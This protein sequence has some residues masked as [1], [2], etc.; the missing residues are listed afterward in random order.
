MCIYETQGPSMPVAHIR[1]G[2][3]RILETLGIARKLSYNQTRNLHRLPHRLHSLAT[4]STNIR[5]LRRF[6]IL[7]ASIDAFVSERVTRSGIQANMLYPESL[8]RVTPSY[9]LVTE[10]IL[11]KSGLCC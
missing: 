10:V 6:R 5:Q 3:T 9:K 8:M 2:V 11:L 4:P 1:L 7:V